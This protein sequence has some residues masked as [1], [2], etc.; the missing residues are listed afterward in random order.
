VAFDLPGGKC[1]VVWRQGDSREVKLG[2]FRQRQPM[3]PLDEPL[4]FSIEVRLLG[5]ALLFIGLGTYDYVAYFHCDLTK[6]D[7]TWMW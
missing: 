5:V 7:G 3:P 2:P 6:M 4:T 1:G